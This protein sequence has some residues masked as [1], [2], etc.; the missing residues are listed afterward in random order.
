MLLLNMAGAAFK[1]GRC[2][3]Q[4]KY[5]DQQL[6]IDNAL[7]NVHDKILQK[8]IRHLYDLRLNKLK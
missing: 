4:M 3:E 7:V 8:Q 5:N 2:L 1:Y 6:Q